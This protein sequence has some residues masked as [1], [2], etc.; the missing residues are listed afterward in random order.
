[1]IVMKT[2]TS[3][4][5]EIRFVHCQSSGGK[6]SHDDGLPL[7]SITSH[8]LVLF[9][10]FLAGYRRTWT[11]AIKIRRSTAKIMTHTRS[12]SVSIVS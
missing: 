10:L 6:N 5:C 3:L 12:G 11:A 4:C 7:I 2:K 1:M 8:Y 9:C